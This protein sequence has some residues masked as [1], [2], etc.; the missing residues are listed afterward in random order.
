MLEMAE[1]LDRHFDDDESE[2]Y[3]MGRLSAEKVERLEEHLLV[4]EACRVKVT[5]SDTY[6]AAMRRAAAHLKRAPKT[7]AG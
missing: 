5:D 7:Q 2:L 3:S 1:E 4:C 6:V